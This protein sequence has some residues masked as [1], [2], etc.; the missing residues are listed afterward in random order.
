MI[1]YSE[2][3]LSRGWHFIMVLC[4]YTCNFQMMQRRPSLEP[5]SYYWWV[6][7]S[8]FA[9]IFLLLMDFLVNVA[10]KSPCFRVM[11]IYTRG[12][13]LLLSKVEHNQ[14]GV[15][16]PLTTYKFGRFMDKNLWRIF[17]SHSVQFFFGCSP[18]TIYS[19][20]HDYA[21]VTP[22][23]ETVGIFIMLMVILMIEELL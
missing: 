1:S 9:H 19:L 15:R 2:K 7:S 11:V 18:G 20:N 13:M 4:P 10:E 12:S 6:I 16:N 21:F 5:S 23:L 22:K 17:L 14:S 8:S 3:G